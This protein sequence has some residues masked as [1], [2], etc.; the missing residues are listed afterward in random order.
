MLGMNHH[1]IHCCN[2]KPLIKFIH[3]YIPLLQLLDKNPYTLT[4]GIALQPII[5]RETFNTVKRKSAERDPAQAAYKSSGP[6]LYIL[7][8]TL[9]CPM[10][11]VNM[12]T[13]SNSRNSRGN[14]RYYHCGTYHRKGSKACKRNGISK[15]A[16]EAAVLNALV[17]EF[18]LLAFP[19]SLEGEI[20]KYLDYQ[21]REI[22]FQLARIDDDLKHLKRRIDLAAKESESKKQ[23]FVA[24]YVIE[25]E[26]EQKKLDRSREEILTKR[27]EPTLTSEQ[28]T[29]IR[30]KIK[31]FATRI[32]IA[33]P[34]E[35]NRL[36][37]DYVTSIMMDQFSGNYKLNMKIPFPS[38]VMDVS[39]V[40][41]KTIYFNLDLQ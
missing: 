35:L 27:V 33:P 32:R 16:I 4:L 30:D 19:G 9:K 18:S 25:L 11:G 22:S 23:E 21:N 29:L 41:E 24:Q 7:R 3:K 10:C 31:N 6:S 2:P 1:H 39:V 37:K 8:G 36:L 13:G 26:S 34:D 20:Q 12:V 17:R 14:T 40:L 5:D 28:L 15:D 38:S